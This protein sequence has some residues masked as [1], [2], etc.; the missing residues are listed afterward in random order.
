MLPTPYYRPSKPAAD[1]TGGRYI[2]DSPR[3]SSRKSRRVTQRLPMTRFSVFTIRQSA[4]PNRP[5]DSYYSDEGRV[6]VICE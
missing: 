3:H 1:R 6:S 4:F 2:L 5:A